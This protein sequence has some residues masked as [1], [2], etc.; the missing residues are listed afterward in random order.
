M[1]VWKVGP[2]IDVLL[3]DVFIYVVTVPLLPE[4]TLHLSGFDLTQ[5][6]G[7]FSSPII[8]I[9]A[10]ARI[11]ITR[12]NRRYHIVHQ[13]ISVGQKGAVGYVAQH[14]LKLNLVSEYECKPID[15]EFWTGETLK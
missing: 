9:D 14:W 5:G 3:T 1:N 7:R 8:D 2:G 13:K 4:R 11:V 6:Y 12:S 10:E 15:D